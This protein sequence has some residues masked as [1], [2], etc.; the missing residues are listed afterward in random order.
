MNVTVYGR[1]GCQP[2]IATKRRLDTLGVLYRFVD[3]DQP[4]Q[5]TN[6]ELLRLAGVT[7]LPHVVVHDEHRNNASWSGF[8]PDLLDRLAA[9]PLS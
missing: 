8:R 3:L 5:K 6:A 2:C 1:P 4:D 7:H 9:D